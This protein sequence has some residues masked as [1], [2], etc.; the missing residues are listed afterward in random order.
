M[1]DIVTAANGKLVQWRPQVSPGFLY[2]PLALNLG[3]STGKRRYGHPAFTGILPEPWLP[4]KKGQTLVNGHRNG[5]LRIPLDSTNGIVLSLRNRY[6]MLRKKVTR[7]A[8][9]T[10]NGESNDGEAQPAVAE[11]HATNPWVDADAPGPSSHP[12]SNLHRLS[13]DPGSGVIMLPEGDDWLMDDDDDSSDEYGH[14][15]PP[16]GEVTRNA[17]QEDLAHVS[18][19][20]AVSASPKRRYGTYYHHPERR[21]ATIPGAFP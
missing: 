8:P 15:V 10:A 13:F 12:Q 9:A 7:R 2:W 21:R 14:T 20:S 19:A 4:L 1:S 11:A 3:L 5:L 6:S 18:S 16:S 17:S